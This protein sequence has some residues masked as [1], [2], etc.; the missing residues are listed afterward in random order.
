MMQEQP[1]IQHDLPP[2]QDHEGRPIR[3][4][5][6]VRSFDFE[7]RELEGDRASFI[8]GIVVGVE[9]SSFDCDRYAV[10]VT[11]RVGGG[12]ELPLPESLTVFPPLN[13]TG[14]ALGGVCDGVRVIVPTE[15]ELQAAAAV[16]ELWVH[17]MGTWY[18]AEYVRT[19]K[20]GTVVLRYTSGTGTTRDK[21]VDP[22]NSGIR[23]G[24]RPDH[25]RGAAAR[26]AKESM[27][28]ALRGGAR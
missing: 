13:G 23:L 22:T 14:T 12:A 7:G 28:A 2:T 6:R 24:E 17:A 16:G 21:T 1:K 11:R 15:Q 5:T 9:Q 10:H 27:R 19:K 8:E 20:T 26:Q 18:A 25:R 4:G 3:L